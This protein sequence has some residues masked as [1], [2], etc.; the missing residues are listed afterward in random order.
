M[1]F[2]FLL[3]SSKEL[4]GILGVETLG[5]S[6]LVWLWLLQG[7]VPT[8]YTVISMFPDYMSNSHLKAI[9]I[10]HELLSFPLICWL[11]E[12]P[13]RLCVQLASCGPIIVFCQVQVRHLYTDLITHDM[14]Q[15]ESSKGKSSGTKNTVLSV[16]HSAFLWWFQ[17]F[18]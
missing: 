14:L 17:S 9:F 8:V 15:L 11:Q 16:L 7:R 13:W 12:A 5:R 1:F 3:M 18:S 4:Q 10:W 6:T 2:I